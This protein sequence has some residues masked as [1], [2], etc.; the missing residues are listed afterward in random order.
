ML[1]GELKLLGS[2]GAVAEID[3]F[4]NDTFAQPAKHQIP[5]LLG[6]IQRMGK[7]KAQLFQG[8][9]EAAQQLQQT[10]AHNYSRQGHNNS[11]SI[12]SMVKQH[13]HCP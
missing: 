11:S 10:A 5:K 6:W 12:Y 4:L 3:K 13:N 1:Q 2:S 7:V 8:Q 9:L